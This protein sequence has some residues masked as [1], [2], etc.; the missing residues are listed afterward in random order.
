[1][2]SE[3]WHRWSCAVRGDYI[4]EEWLCTRALSVFKPTLWR[5]VHGV[6]G[7]K[8]TRGRAATCRIWA[9]SGPRLVS[10][11]HGQM[12]ALGNAESV[13]FFEPLGRLE[14]KNFNEGRTVG[15]RSQN[16]C[17]LLAQVPVTAQGPKK[18]QNRSNGSKFSLSLLFPA[19]LFLQSSSS[20][21]GDSCT[22]HHFE[23]THFQ[24]RMCLRSW[25][26]NLS[27]LKAETCTVLCLGELNFQCPSG[28]RYRADKEELLL[29][30][31]TE[32]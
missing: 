8:R 26:Q 27:P 20:V 13:D 23:A 28:F 6:C 4:P 17:F 11:D 12:S 29:R 10:S 9:G 3:M 22:L 19:E 21:H 30:L 5:L 14:R 31:L 2:H 7:R 1:M 32:L 18:D 16:A 24:I 25:Q 15:R